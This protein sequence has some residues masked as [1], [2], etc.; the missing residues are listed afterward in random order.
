MSEYIGVPPSSENTNQMNNNTSFNSSFDNNFNGDSGNYNEFNDNVNEQVSDD[1]FDAVEKFKNYMM[2]ASAKNISQNTTQNEIEHISEEEYQRAL[3]EQRLKEEKE[4]EEKR[5][6]EESLKELVF[7]GYM[8]KTVTLYDKKWTFHVLSMDEIRQ[9][10]HDADAYEG[11]AYNIALRLM[12]LSRALD[13]VDGAIFLNKDECTNFLYKLPIT[14]LMKVY[15]EYFQLSLEQDKHTFNIEELK[16]LVNDNFSRIKYKVMRAAGALPTETRCKE[17]TSAQWLWYYFNLEEDLVEERDKA[18]NHYDYLGMYINP[19]LAKIVSEQNAARRKQE[20]QAKIKDK[21]NYV[22]ERLFG[23]ANV[24][25]ED[26]VVNTEFE[27]EL[28][29]AIKKS[30]GDVNDIT[31]LPDD[32]SAGNPYESQEDFMERV[33]AFAQFAG[34]SYG[35]EKPVKPAKAKIN[36]KAAYH[37]RPNLAEGEYLPEFDERET[38]DGKLREELKKEIKENNVKNADH[39]IINGNKIEK[40]ETS[41]NDIQMPEIQKSNDNIDDWLQ[42][43]QSNNP[44]QNPFNNSFDA[45]NVSNIPKSDQKL[46]HLPPEDL[47]DDMDYFDYDDDN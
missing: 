32:T 2:N 27:K 47:T 5:K 24:V 14:I 38:P 23:D 20:A 39:F 36:Y 7:S 45:N 19:K 11:I 16:E 31:E 13:S 6:L 4:Q 9:A 21:N 46:G 35:Y 42:Q 3:E 12:I 8:S 30:G 37:A 22:K 40:V 26:T 15:D 18:Q 33:K 41:E 28:M 29:E 44:Y 25:G 43:V 1:H 34:T 17:M 10:Y